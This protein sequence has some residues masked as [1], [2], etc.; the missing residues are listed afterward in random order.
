[1]VDLYGINAHGFTDVHDGWRAVCD[2]LAAYLGA[3]KLG[4]RFSFADAQANVG[5]QGPAELDGLAGAARKTA[6]VANGTFCVSEEL[7]ARL[8]CGMADA[9]GACF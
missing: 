6:R 2:Q 9:S 3:Q 4:R 7:D 1:M 8:L 5:T